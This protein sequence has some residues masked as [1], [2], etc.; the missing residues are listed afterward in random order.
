MQLAPNNGSDRQHDMR[1]PQVA[2]DLLH[3]IQMLHERIIVLEHDNA[4][5]KCEAA[6]AARVNRIMLDRVAEAQGH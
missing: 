3:L 6:F 1:E 2:G 4:E 5:M